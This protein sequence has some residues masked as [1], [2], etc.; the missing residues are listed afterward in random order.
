MAETSSTP[1]LNKAAR[2]GALTQQSDAI[3]GLCLRVNRGESLTSADLAAAGF[4]P[5]LNF[6]ALNTSGVEVALIKN[7][8]TKRCGGS[9]MGSTPM[10]I[11]NVYPFI[12][13]SL[14]DNGYHEVT[15]SSPSKRFSNGKL[16]VEL[17]GSSSQSYG[18]WSVAYDLS[19]IQDAL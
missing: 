1:P 13:K 4:Q 6:H 14:A 8:R 9:Y 12:Q 19:P 7:D 18:V 10:N 3:V 2:D 15:S 5:R 16:T 11:H 17:T